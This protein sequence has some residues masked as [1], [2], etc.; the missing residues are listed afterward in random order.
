[1]VVSCTSRRS[2]VA[3]ELCRSQSLDT[4]SR[5]A[6]EE[7]VSVYAHCFHRW[8]V[9]SADVHHWQTFTKTHLQTSWGSQSLVRQKL[10]VD[11]VFCF[12]RVFSFILIA[13]LCCGALP[14]HE[15]RKALLGMPSVMQHLSPFCYC[16]YIFAQDSSSMYS[17]QLIFS[18]KTFIVA[19]VFVC[20]LPK[21]IFCRSACSSLALSC[22]MLS[23]GAA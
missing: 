12:I 5:A 1:M 21:P 19:A 11:F 14:L 16:L 18:P 17:L 22:Y 2:C 8:L 15:H 20:L 6:R 13:P 4:R 10:P 23:L 9:L 3:I 7:E